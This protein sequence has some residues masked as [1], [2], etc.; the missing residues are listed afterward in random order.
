MDICKWNFVTTFF[1]WSIRE[2]A[3]CITLTATYSSS[4][5]WH[6]PMWTSDLDLAPSLSLPDGFIYQPIAS[7]INRIMSLLFDLPS[8][9]GSAN[10]YEVILDLVQDIQYEWSLLWTKWQTWF[11]ERPLLIVDY[12]TLGSRWC[13]ALPELIGYFY[14]CRIM[15]RHAYCENLEEEVLSSM[16]EDSIQ[17]YIKHDT[18][19]GVCVA[20]KKSLGEMLEY[21]IVFQIEPFRTS[22]LNFGLRWDLGRRACGIPWGKSHWLAETRNTSTMSLSNE[23]VVLQG[24]LSICSQTTPMKILRSL[25]FREPQS[26]DELC[27]WPLTSVV[28]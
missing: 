22:E 19:E 3:T 21:L 5:W 18:A 13:H 16:L 24:R 8:K 9:I 20:F 4:G 17:S 1:T 6:I 25:G 26:V 27:T 23:Y 7:S 14:G 28:S 11:Y 15:P 10:G 12:R 2:G